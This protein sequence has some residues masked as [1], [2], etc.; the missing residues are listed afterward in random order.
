MAAL[1][2]GQYAQCVA[3][4]LHSLCLGVSHDHAHDPIH[5]RA[6]TAEESG[7]PH[8]RAA[9]SSCRAVEY[10]ASND[11]FP[12]T[13][14]DAVVF[15][16]GN[17]TQSAHYYQLALGHGARGLS[18]P[19]DG[20]PGPRVLRAAL[21][22]GPLRVRRRGGPRRPLLD[23][24]RTH[25]DGVID[26]A[27]EVPD[28]DCSP[29]PARGRDHP[30][31]AARRERRARHRPL[32][33]D[34]DV[35]RHPAHPRRP[36][37]VREARTCPATSRGPRSRHSGRGRRG[38]CS[39]RSTTRGQRRARTDGRLGR[40]L[41]QGHG[42]HEHGR[43]IGDDIATEYSALMSKVVA[44]GNHRVKFPLNEPA[45]AKKK[46]QIDEYLEF[47]DGAGCQHIALATGDILRTVRPAARPTAS[48]SSRPPTPTPCSGLFGSV[49]V[50]A[51]RLPCRLGARQRALRRDCAGDDRMSATGGAQAIILFEAALGSAS[52]GSAGRWAAR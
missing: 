28:V 21:R 22:L 38:G 52:L 6:L 5:R 44:S 7:R 45:I 43:F 20:Q 31:R 30:R 4:L 11:P 51:R 13:G 15:V 1:L 14:M 42:L 18:R 19:R 26:L 37:R 16:V 50:L 24:H 32:R 3:V 49:P 2:S 10:D 41:Q 23:E 29:T 36:Q 47:Y 48:S 39:R 34:R 9:P 12:V 8:P 35:R 25:G 40:V 27:I 17:A 33:R 46:S